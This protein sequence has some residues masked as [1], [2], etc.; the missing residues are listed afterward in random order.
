MSRLRRQFDAVFLTGFRAAPWV[1]AACLI[2]SAVAAAASVTYSIGFKLMIDGAIAHDG[3]RIW[4]GAGL[5]AALFTLGWL[6][7]I[8]SG[9]EMSMLTDRV[10]L[11]LGTRIARL[12]AT[13]PTLEHL[14]RPELLRRIEQLTSNR[15][16]LAGSPGQLFRL[17]G[18]ALRAIGIVVLLATV[19]LPLLV[20]PLLALA[21]ALA[22]RRAAR[23]QQR[24]DDDLAEK[25]RLLTDLFTLAT[26]ASSARELRTYGVTEP[27]ARRHAELADVIRRDSV[28]AAV[29]SAAWEAVGWGVFAVGVVAAIVILVLRAAHGHVSPGSVVMSVTLM[30][31]AQT[32]ISRSTDTMGSFNT[33]RNAADQLLWLEDHA[34]SFESAGRLRAKPPARM[35]RSLTLEG[36][37]FAYPGA[38]DHTVLGPLELELPAGRSI[39]VVGENGAGKTTLVKLLCGMYLP[40]AGRILLDDVDLAQIDIVA[41][42]ERVSATFQDFVRFHLPLRDSVGVGDLYRL[43]DDAAVRSALDRAGGGSLE[44]ELADGLATQ[45]GGRYTGGRELSGGQW[46]RL[47]LAR[48]LMRENPLLIVLDEPTASLDARTEGLLFERYVQA[49]RVAGE[50]QGTITLMVSHRFSTVRSADLIVVLENG[51]IAEVGSHRALIEAHGTYA[52]LYEL[53]ARAYA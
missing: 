46:Q 12:V 30:R 47:A 16:T 37:E 18:Q 14:E 27:L 19:Y 5:V 8:V 21:P 33:A 41:W 13:L 45:V 10:N 48:G 31:R 39:A 15:R 29:R 1:A 23:V 22:D 17:L 49:A 44:G 24:S 51:R 2:M 11:R 7:A 40:S 53:Q 36:L 26:T 3:T 42:R 35:S 28:R 25:R 4:L 43:G 20:I 38:E 50:A 34:R 52:E 6:L 32:Q 9:W